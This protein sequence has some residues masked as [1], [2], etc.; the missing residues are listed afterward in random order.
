MSS[1]KNENCY[2][3]KLG[4]EA[5]LSERANELEAAAASGNCRKLLQLIRATGSKKSDVS[6]TICEDDGMPVTNSHRCL[7]R[8]TELFEGQ[9]N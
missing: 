2:I 1:T 8:W 6:E 5:S 7:E 3:I 9:F 4:R